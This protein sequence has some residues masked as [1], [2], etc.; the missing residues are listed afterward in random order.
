MNRHEFNNSEIK[1]E[2]NQNPSDNNWTVEHERI[3]LMLH[4]YANIQYNLYHE[5]YIRYKQKLSYYRI[6]IIVIG[7]LM[8]L[9]SISNTSYV[10]QEYVAYV[11]L[12]VG[13][14]NVIS[15]IISMIEAYK[16]IDSIKTKSLESYIVYKQINDELSLILRLPHKDRT[17]SG[18]VTINKYFKIFEKC[19]YTSPVLKIK[20]IDLFELNSLD[21]INIEIYNKNVNKN[22]KDAFKNF[23]SKITTPIK[24]KFSTKTNIIVSDS[25][26]D[27]LYNN[28][29][30][31]NSS[32]DIHSNN[33]NGNIHSNNSNGNM[34]ND[35]DNNS[36]N[37][38]NS[39]G[40]INNNNNNSNN[41]NNNSNNSNENINNNN[42]NNNSNSNGNSNSN[43]NN[44]FKNINNS[45]NSNKNS[46][47]NSNDTINNINNTIKNIKN[48][49]DD[50]YNIGN[51]PINNINNINNNNNDD[52]DD[53][54]NYNCINDIDDL[55]KLTNTILNTAKPTLQK[56]I[57]NKLQIKKINI[58]KYMKQ[59]EN[60][61]NEL[62]EIINNDLTVK[63][64]NLQI[65]YDSKD[66]ED[67]DKTNEQQ[68]IEEIINK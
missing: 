49:I 27:E 59:K 18:V 16:K 4:K 15:T 14:S 7:G 66:D 51:I 34:N 36:N 30:T 29:E 17:D 3:L 41:S 37:S 43:S 44:S 1:V 52:N 47:N 8:G 53:N 61:N 31:G 22:W 63:K 5:T 67:S 2:N 24:K 42:N 68:H 19:Q 60:I 46:N 11:S 64:N 23:G 9:L 40:N 39:N 13:I 56:K 58:G 33:S 65:M 45:S 35:N 38:N 12:L 26:I 10:P 50:C 57:N 48:D 21:D 25:N 20:A 54:D 55:K 28:I 6:P 32:G 62:S